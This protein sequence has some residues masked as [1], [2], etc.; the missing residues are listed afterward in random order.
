MGIDLDFS[1]ISKEFSRTDKSEK[2]ER[3]EWSQD[4]IKKTLKKQKNLCRE[5]GKFMDEFTDEKHHADG[6]NS[7]NDCSNL[8]IVHANCHRKITRH[9]KLAKNAIKKKIKKD[10]EKKKGPLDINLDF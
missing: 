10:T 9:Q 6:D 2:S 7:N 3:K 4:C 1:G 8:W 5:C